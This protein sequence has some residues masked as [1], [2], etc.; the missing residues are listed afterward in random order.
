MLLEDRD[1]LSV[2][3]VLCA[4]DRVHVHKSAVFEE[5]ATDV[6]LTWRPQ[7]HPC[8]AVGMQWG[9]VSCCNR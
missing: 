4:Q 9:D 7:G 3:C 8:L 1:G 2:L 5:E 6:A